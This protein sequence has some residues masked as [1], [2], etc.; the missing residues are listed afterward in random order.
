MNE[1]LSATTV[2]VLAG[3]T[4]FVAWW[5][6]L[7]VGTIMGAFMGAVFFVISSIELS[8][9]VRAGYFSISFF[10]GIITAPIA[11]EVIGGILR[12]K[13]QPPEALG[14]L[15]ASSVAIKLLLFST[16]PDGLRAMLSRV[17]DFIG[18]FGSGGK[19]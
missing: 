8:R 10:L 12:T 15:L 13:A 2:T 5:N 11:T 6:N 9:F 1:P 19:R 7:D 4:G 14:A 3:T 18:Q 17:G 16:S